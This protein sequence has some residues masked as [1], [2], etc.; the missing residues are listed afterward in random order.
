MTTFHSVLKIVYRRLGQPNFLRWLQWPTIFNLLD[1]K[2]DSVILDLGAGPMQYAVRLAKGS[3][4]QVIAIDWDIS[5]DHAALARR[6]DITALRADGQALPLADRSVDRIVMSSL[7]HMVPEPKRLLLECCRV[8]KPNGHLVLSVPNHY[9]FIPAM[10]H[11]KKW[12]AFRKMFRLP[13]DDVALTALL[14]QRFGVGGPQGY[15]SASDLESLLRA[16]DFQVEEHRYAPGRI[17]SWLWEMGVVAY[18]RFG[19]KALH[20]LFLFYPLAR[21]CEILVTP[22]SGSEHI[23]KATPSL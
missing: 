10:F 13:S 2:A 23:V 12:S 21:L 22:T 17:G 16:C 6:Y 8:L 7:L 18:V 20:A 14:N 9:Q 11:R 3:C 4:G 1:V 19:N 5:A 15:Y